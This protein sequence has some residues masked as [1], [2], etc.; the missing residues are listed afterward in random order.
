MTPTERI[1]PRWRLLVL[2]AAFVL[3]PAWARAAII[4][5]I[6]YTDLTDPAEPALTGNPEAWDWYTASD[7]G[8]TCLNASTCTTQFQAGAGIEADGQQL[9]GLIPGENVTLDQTWTYQIDI[10][11]QATGAWEMTVDSSLFGAMTINDHGEAGDAE[12]TIGDLTGTLAT[13]GL[14]SSGS[15]D[16]LV[17][18]T[19]PDTVVSSSDV[20]EGFS[21]TSLGSFQVTGGFGDTTVSMVFTLEGDLRSSCGGVGCAEGGDEAAIRLGMPTPGGGDILFFSAGDYPGPVVSDPTSAHGHFLEVAVFVP[22]PGL[23]LLL[24]PALALLPGLR[25]RT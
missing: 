1:G 9:F 10:Q 25:R 21:R 22:E 8:S 18:Q 14:S 16:L 15:L 20:D 2:L 3:L 4:T 19:D 12:V 5:G 17:L 23:G 6:T 24:L 13:S 7:F 11:V